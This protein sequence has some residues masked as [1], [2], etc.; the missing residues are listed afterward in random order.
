MQSGSEAIMSDK[1]ALPSFLILVRCN[2]VGDV[3]VLVRHWA[4]GAFLVLV[5]VPEGI[6]I[7]FIL[8]DLPKTDDNATTLT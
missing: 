3:S 1:L 4:D 2:P 5:P 6:A 8:I 7:R